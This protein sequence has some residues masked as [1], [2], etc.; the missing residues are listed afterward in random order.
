MIIKYEAYNFNDKV[1]ATGSVRML[2]YDSKKIDKHLLDRIGSSYSHHKVI[3]YYQEEP[4][5]NTQ[6]FEWL[7]DMF[8]IK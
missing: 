5:K 6:G 3:T 7:K 8:N 2:Q 4:E 1:I